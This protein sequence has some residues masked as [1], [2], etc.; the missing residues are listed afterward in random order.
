[1]T[2]NNNI[3]SLAIIFASITLPSNV[4]A[5]SAGE[6]QIRVQT[7]APKKN[8]ETAFSYL[9]EWRKDSDVTHRSNGLTFI[10]GPDRTKPTT[11]VEAARRIA[12]ALNDAMSYESPI[13]RGAT[14]IATKGKPELL[15]SN[16]EGFDFTKVTFRDYSNQ[17][18][19]YSIPGKSFSA[20]S[21][22]VAIDIV[23]G[24]DIE[25]M[26]GF[27]AGIEAKTNG[28]FVRLTLDGGEPIEIKTDGKTK[29]EIE[30]E[31]AQ[32]LGTKARFS[33]EPIYPN[34]LESGSRNYKPFDGGE[35]QLF[36]LGAQ[37]I[38]IDINDSGLG[39]LAKFDFPD[40]NKPTDVANKIPYIVG[41]LV[42]GII[43]YVFYSSKIK[44]KEEDQEA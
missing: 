26:E 40:V 5:L 21:V 42:A 19:T 33:K 7:S 20:V 22:N 18:L 12:K 37:S 15:V 9:V 13:S 38:T 23:Y 6:D 32:A 43:G 14:A 2:I 1:M 34:Y 29:E 8:D 39:V 36:G 30:T 3:L 31:L 17:E 16:K 24:A 11:D 10:H 27:S 4:S 41:A 44:N 25:N 35:I 28:G